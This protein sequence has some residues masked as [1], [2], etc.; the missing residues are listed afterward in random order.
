[1]LVLSR[2]RSIQIEE[3][4][5]KAKPR[6]GMCNLTAQPSTVQAQT[7]EMIWAPMG[8]DVVGGAQSLQRWSQGT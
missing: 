4:W 6:F 3:K 2:L 8:Y 1:L 5:S 7:P